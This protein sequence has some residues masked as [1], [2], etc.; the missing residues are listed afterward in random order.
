MSR[1][2]AIAAL[3]DWLAPRVQNRGAPAGRSG[4][5]AVA[6]ARQSGRIAKSESGGVRG[7]GH[8]LDAARRD[9]TGDPARM[10]V[11]RLADPEEVGPGADRFQELQEPGL[12]PKRRVSSRHADRQIHAERY[13]RALRLRAQHVQEGRRVA[14][15]P[16]RGQPPAGAVPVRDRGPTFAGIDAPIGMRGE[17]ASG[18]QRFVGA[19]QQAPEE[20]RRLGGFRGFD[21]FGFGFFLGQPVALLGGQPLVQAQARLGGASGFV[22]ALALGH[23]FR[24]LHG[25]SPAGHSRWTRPAGGPGSGASSG[26]DQAGP[27]GYAGLAAGEQ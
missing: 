5:G 3:P 12:G 24:L 6:G 9:R 8:A 14:D 26:L 15:Q 11:E 4:G 7:A 16:R 25:N 18:P 20:A 19:I 1:H 23:L 13:R 17:D 22:G 27:R 10:S 21:G 2:A